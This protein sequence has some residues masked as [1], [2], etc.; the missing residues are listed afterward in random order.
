MK[1]PFT[2]AII[3]CSF[4]FLSSLLKGQYYPI[5]RGYSHVL[6]TFPER[7]YPTYAD[8]FYPVGWSPDG[9]FA[10]FIESNCDPIGTNPFFVIQDMK[11]DSVLES[12]GGESMAHRQFHTVDELWAGKRR[13]F[14][15]IMAWYGIEN[16]TNYVLD[17][18]L[19]YSYQGMGYEF[20]L[21]RESFDTTYAANGTRELRI[22]VTRNDSVPANDTLSSGEMVSR[23]QQKVIFS[24]TVGFMHAL[25]HT[26]IEAFKS[27]NIRMLFSQIG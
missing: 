21:Y 10:Y 23:V 14:M 11:T 12:Y 27:T 7:G 24:D 13:E 1:K 22:T 3:F 9:L 4:F 26:L 19:P 16:D 25:P 8:K 15:D 20:D 18:S 17:E 5:P 2:F 6:S